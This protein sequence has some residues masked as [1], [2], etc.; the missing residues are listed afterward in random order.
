[1]ALNIKLQ[2]YRGTKASLSTLASTGFAGV[3]AYTTD[4][5]E[6]FVDTGAGTGIPTAWAPLK[7]THSV[8]TAANVAGLLTLPT[9]NIGDFAIVTSTGVTYILT[10]LPSTIG[11][12]WSAMTQPDVTGTAFV[13]HE[14]VTNITS[15]GIQHL[16]QPAFS[17]ISGQL[18]QTQ[19][20]TSIGAGS[21]LTN[22]D[23]GSF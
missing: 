9:A 23:C 18:A 20:P 1:M 6:I 4:T 13:A 12:N 10:A 17:D 5:F 8:F 3:L 16:S 15:D 11:G 21:A 14:W 19:L 7:T 22:V 2:T